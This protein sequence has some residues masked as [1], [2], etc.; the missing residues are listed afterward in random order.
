MWKTTL[1]RLTVNKE[2]D[3]RETNRLCESENLMEMMADISI[4]GECTGRILD[5]GGG[6]L[7]SE[8]AAELLMHI[9]RHKWFLSEQLGRDVGIKVAC[10]DY[11]ENMHSIQAEL[12]EPERDHLLKEL[13]PRLG[14]GF[15]RTVQEHTSLDSIREIFG[16][17]LST[18][19][20][21][22]ILKYPGGE[23]LGGELR[24]IT[25]LVSDIREFTRTT[26]SLEPGRVLEIINRYLEKMTD[27]IMKH[28]GTIDEFTGDGILVFFGAPT[29]VPDHCKRAVACALEMQRAMDGLN[30]G[31]LRLGLPELQMGIGINSGELIVGNIGSEK[32]KKYGAVGL[33]IN[34]AFRIQSEAEGGEILVS[35]TVFHKVGAEL[36]VE[37]TRQ[38]ALKGIEQDVILYLVEGFRGKTGLGTSTGEV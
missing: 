31:N 23:E 25:I 27:I 22:E 5:Y 32:R 14:A 38:C 11:I 7:Q 29:F 33:P 2:R 26:E 37:G 4:P 36:L 10:L 16:R 8:L 24:E 34:L 20:V 12:D 13:G 6:Q 17:Y 35:P 30:T 19:V 18:E 21:D 3:S 15:Y 28:G 1:G 9:L